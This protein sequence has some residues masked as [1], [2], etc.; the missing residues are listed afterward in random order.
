VGGGA[1]VQTGDRLHC[2]LAA[3]LERGALRC[4]FVD[5]CAIGLADAQLV[6]ARGVLPWASA[7]EQAFDV[8]AAGGELGLTTGEVL[9]RLGTLACALV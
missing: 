8:V 3:L 1:S 6:D 2:V 5:T 9:R 4:Q 7:A